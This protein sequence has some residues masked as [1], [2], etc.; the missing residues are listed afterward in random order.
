MA[1]HS[2]VRSAFD[3]LVALG[4]W[5]SEQH[6]LKALLLQVHPKF[7]LKPFVGGGVGGWRGGDDL[8]MQTTTLILK[9]YLGGA[10][11]IY[12]LFLGKLHSKSI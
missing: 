4:N 3:G 5:S 9:G 2:S 7:L 6:I 1:R 12:P 10:L 8:T 11:T